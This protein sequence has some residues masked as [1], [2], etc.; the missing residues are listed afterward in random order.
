MDRCDCFKIIVT[1][2]HSRVDVRAL[3]VEMSKSLLCEIDTE[4]LQPSKPN[5]CT[6]D[7]PWND[8]RRITVFPI[9][10]RGSGL[11][12]FRIPGETP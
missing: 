11:C 3:I 9:I 4:K 10:R 5:T 7:V 6:V 8:F 2:R 12:S 1:D